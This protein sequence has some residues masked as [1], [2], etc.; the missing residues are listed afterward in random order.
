ME[1]YKV[2]DAHLLRSGRKLVVDVEA[3]DPLTFEILE[4]DNI[5]AFARV[6]N[7]YEKSRGLS[8]IRN[9]LRT[10]CDNSAVFQPEKRQV[11]AYGTSEFGNE[12]ATKDR[13]PT[14]QRN[15]KIIPKN[16]VSLYL[17]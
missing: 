16:N 9:V 12:I 11:F 4:N 7:D 5:N 10:S 17:G 2:R 8:V 13:R 3:K 1:L 15:E 14:P 6:I